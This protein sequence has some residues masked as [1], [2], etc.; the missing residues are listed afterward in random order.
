MHLSDPNP[1]ERKKVIFNLKFVNNFEDVPCGCC[2]LTDV[3][4]LLVI[5]RDLQCN[6]LC[7]Q[8]LENLLDRS[9][10]YLGIY[11]KF[12]KMSVL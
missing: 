6:V 3:F 8:D 4:Y 12:I 11:S 7:L 9:G 1:L 2:S 5:S 10:G